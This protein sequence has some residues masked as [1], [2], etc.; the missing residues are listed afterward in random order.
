MQQFPYRAEDRGEYFLLS[1]YNIP[2]LKGNSSQLWSK[3]DMQEFHGRSSRFRVVSQGFVRPCPVHSRTAVCE[4]SPGWDWHCPQGK[5]PPRECSGFRAHQ[6]GT[7]EQGG[8]V[9]PGRW[10]INSGIWLGPSAAWSSKGFAP[11]ASG[12]RKGLL[13][14]SEEHT[15]VIRGRIRNINQKQLHYSP[16][17][18]GI[19]NLL[20]LTQQ[21][22]PKHIPSQTPK[23][24]KGPKPS[25]NERG[26]EWIQ[27]V[28]YA[29]P[30][31]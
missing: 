15:K 16:D 29:T 13:L 12:A 30:H 24:C 3:C 31:T 11:G 2:L 23:L 4:E 22:T 6:W 1:K 17:F 5:E 26:K 14:S 9:W 20:P 10:G 28:Y 7:G 18:W 25:I 8:V 19:T 21:L 27:A